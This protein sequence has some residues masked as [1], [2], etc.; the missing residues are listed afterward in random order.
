[1][2][3]VTVPDDLWLDQ[4]QGSSL[5]ARAAALSHDWAFVRWIS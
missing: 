5:P 3:G 4:R 2:R 1:M